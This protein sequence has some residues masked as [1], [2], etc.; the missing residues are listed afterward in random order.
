MTTRKGTG[1][2]SARRATV[3]G[4]VGAILG[5]VCAAVVV[6][7]PPAGWGLLLYGIPIGGALGV[8]VGILVWSISSALFRLGSRVNVGV[9]WVLSIAVAT[10]ASA[11]TVLVA[12]S[13]V[14][15]V[16]VVG[17]AVLGAGCAALDNAVS[18]RVS[19]AAIP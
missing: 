12:L 19:R 15:P 18:G 13:P 8:A 9:G 14:T 3:A 16:L 11:G 5:I 17:A 7:A 4:V 1:P 2:G 6:S 10:A